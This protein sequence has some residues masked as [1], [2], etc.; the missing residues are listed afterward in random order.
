[1]K[2]CS[3]NQFTNVRLSITLNFKKHEKG[4]HLVTLNAEL[5]FD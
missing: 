4:E 2:I 1:M 3:N 5:L